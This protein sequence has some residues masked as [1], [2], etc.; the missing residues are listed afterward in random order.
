M[1]YEQ[2]YDMQTKATMSAPLGVA[3]EKLEA[4]V[5]ETVVQA[6]RMRKRI[7]P[8]VSRAENPSPNG[9]V[10]SAAAGTSDV[11]QKVFALAARLEE[12]SANISRWCNQLEI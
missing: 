9:G 7:D 3:L 2:D 10:L 11:V 1:G 8:L 6:E 4:M 12:V 5:T